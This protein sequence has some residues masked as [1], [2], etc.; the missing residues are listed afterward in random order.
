MEM[1]TNTKQKPAS[2]HIAKWCYIFLSTTTVLAII[3]WLLIGN[4]DT[5]SKRFFYLEIYFVIQLQ[6]VRWPF[7]YRT[8]MMNENETNNN[9]SYHPRREHPRV[10]GNTTDDCRLPILNPCDPTIIKSIDPSYHPRKNCEIKSQVRSRL[11]NGELQ[12]IGRFVFA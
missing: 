11:E 1:I 12:I 9:C 8:I 10:I 4:P 5:V 3:C 2:I 6:A 7:D